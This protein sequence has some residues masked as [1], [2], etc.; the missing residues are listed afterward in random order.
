MRTI[1]KA[2]LSLQ[3]VHNKYSYLIYSSFTAVHFQMKWCKCY[4]SLHFFEF[5]KCVYENQSDD[6]IV[7][8]F[9]I[10]NHFIEIFPL[11][12]CSFL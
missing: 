3:H 8:Q 4:I 12:C 10:I 9:I 7:A 11:L 1:D 5:Q 6:G 2:Y